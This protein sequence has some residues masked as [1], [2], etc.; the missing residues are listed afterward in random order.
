MGL[1]KSIG[2]V[3]GGIAKTVG[4]VASKVADVA[5]KVADVAGKAV[6]IMQAP[7][8]AL[9]GFIKKAA[10]S[11]LDKLP[12][13]LGNMIKPFA[14][15]VIDGG[16]AMLSKSNLGSIFEFAKKLAPKVGQLADFAEKVK[17][18][19]EKV[20]TF[21]NPAIRDSAMNNMREMFSSAQADGLAARYAA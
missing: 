4:N 8:Q 10:G 6:K 14:E 9:S 12:F 1:F 21:T 16:M 17:Q 5:G 13:N 11:L 2:K 7:E 15:K 18:T 20:G 19:A 3:I